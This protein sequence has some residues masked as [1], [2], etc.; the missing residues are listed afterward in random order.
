MFVGGGC[1]WSEVGRRVL[2]E[3]SGEEGVGGAKWEGRVLVE[4]SRGEG[5]GGV[6]WGERVGG[7]K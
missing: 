7:A 6:K 1:W 5:V 3:R 4:R 2:V